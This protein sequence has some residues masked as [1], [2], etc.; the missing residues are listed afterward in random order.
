MILTSI[1]IMMPEVLLDGLCSLLDPPLRLTLPHNRAC[2]HLLT[3]ILSPHLLAPHSPTAFFGL[4]LAVMSLAPNRGQLGTYLT[5]NGANLFH[6]SVDFIQNLS[7]N[8]FIWVNSHLAQTIAFPVSFPTC[9]PIPLPPSPLNNHKPLTIS[10]DNRGQI[11]KAIDGRVPLI[12]IRG[13]LYLGGSSDPSRDTM[14]NVNS[15]F[16]GRIIGLD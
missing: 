15:T 1:M 13:N 7:L 9:Y 11:G 10:L 4:L 2:I 14:G 5:Q 16:R 8:L 3:P 6:L 12:P